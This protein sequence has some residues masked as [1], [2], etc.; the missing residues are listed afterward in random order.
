MCASQSLFTKHMQPYVHTHIHTYIHTH[1][2]TYTHIHTHTH[3][4]SYIYTHTHT[5]IHTHTYT[6]IHTHTCTHTHTHSDLLHVSI[7]C[8]PWI[9]I[10][11]PML[12]FLWSEVRSVRDGVVDDANEHRGWE[13]AHKLQQTVS[14]GMNVTVS[15]TMQTNTEAENQ[16]TSYNR[17][18]HM[19]WTSQTLHNILCSRNRFFFRGYQNVDLIRVRIHSVWHP[20]QI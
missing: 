16:R 6:H 5:Y 15:L 7:H 10:A 4:Y 9:G 1:T 8:H 19:V 18:F 14:Y 2:H 13:P 12:S 3:T 17:Q 20:C 11:V